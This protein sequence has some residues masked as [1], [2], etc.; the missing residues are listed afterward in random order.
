MNNF[1]TVTEISGDDISS[2]QVQRMVHRY[3][4]A[5]KLSLGKDVLEVGCGTGQ[6]LGLLLQSSNS[7][8]G[9]DYSND[10]LS[11]ATKYYQER[12]PLKQFDAQ[13]MPYEDNSK[14]VII[15]FEAIYYVPDAKKFINECKRVLKPG[16]IVLIATAN[17]VLE[18]F[19]PSPFSY[20]Y[21][22]CSELQ[23]LFNEFN[24]QTTFFGYMPISNNVIKSK[25]ISFIKKSAVTLN[26]MPKTMAGKKFLKRF[27]FGKLVTMPHEISGEE[28]EFIDPVKISKDFVNEPGFKVIYCI[29]Q[30]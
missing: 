28:Y 19:N 5:Q 26:L 14:E 1:T 18:D 2:E 30:F 23:T 20:N 21:Y 24:F 10:L 3:Q 27:V 12:L 17:K 8:E 15:L 16:G 13:D 11:V 9:G 7:V 29:A 25:I 6:G 4:W 22:N